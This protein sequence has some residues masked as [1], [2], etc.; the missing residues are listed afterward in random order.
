MTV[1]DG[2][3]DQSASG[4]GLVVNVEL[5]YLPTSPTGI[6]HYAAAAALHYTSVKSRQSCRLVSGATQSA[7]DCFPNTQLR[8]GPRSSLYIY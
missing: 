7:V 5:S 1:R 8:P 6:T 4:W 2:E 3:E